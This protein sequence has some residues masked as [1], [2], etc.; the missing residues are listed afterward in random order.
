MAYTERYVTSA[1]SGGIGTEG[2]PWT[3]AEGLDQA[4][5]SD[6]LN[7]LSDA[8]YSIGADALT[9]AGSYNGRIVIRGYN[10]TIGDLEGQGRNADG[11]LNV[12]GFPV[13]TV[14][15]SL[16]SNAFSI[17]QNLYITGSLTAAI[18]N[19]S[20]PDSVTMIS[21]K[22]ENTAS[23]AS[24]VAANFDNDS[25]L[26]N[27]DYICTDGTHGTICSSDSRAIW[28][29][30][31]FVGN[32]TSAIWLTC[33]EGTIVGCAF[34][35]LGSSGT[36]RAINFETVGNQPLISNCT[37]YNF[38]TCILVPNAGTTQ[39]LVLVNNH[40]TDSS[41]WLDNLFI[42][43]ATYDIIEVNSR[44]R[45]NT[46]PRTGF[47]DSLNIAEV[48]TDTG[49]PETDYENAAA[50]DITLIAAAPGVDAG[51]GM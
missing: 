14:T 40:A 39:N 7:V 3:L 12:T 2:D 36:T 6:R 45:D 51:L 15:G 38:G 32:S 9:N 17:W 19:S 23:S 26:I 13:I 10:S 4:D 31:R 49:G 21:C 20:S 46:T 30:C 35:S 33:R 29:G 24:A 41:K 50:G 25:V 22:I 37:F 48:T 34:I 44:T 47:G 11:T 8:G 18:F 27:N 42:G 28:A 1:S 5:D 16:T 43:T